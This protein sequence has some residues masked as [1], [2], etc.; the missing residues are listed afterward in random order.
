MDYC[1]TLYMQSSL[2]QLY[3]LSLIRPH[4]L[5]NYKQDTQMHKLHFSKDKK[6]TLA[7]YWILLYSSLIFAWM[8]G[9]R[10]LTISM[11]LL[12]NS[13]LRPV[14][15]F[16]AYPRSICSSETRKVITILWKG[17]TMA[18]INKMSMNILSINIL[19]DII[20]ICQ[21]C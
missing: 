19:L 2:L 15:F 3:K 20:C 11:A 21:H 10:N 18:E 13:F 12:C 16:P 4:A 7:T 6:K 8:A 9:F 14:L 1:C 17:K 5:S